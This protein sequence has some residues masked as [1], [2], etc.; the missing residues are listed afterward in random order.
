MMFFLFVS[1]NSFAAEVQDDIGILNKTDIQK[2]QQTKYPFDLTI[3]VTNFTIEGFENYFKNKE[4]VGIGVNPISK[5]TVVTSPTN[6]EI[7]GLSKL[8]N[9]DFTSARYVD[10]ISKIANEYE[11][12]LR[13][14]IM[15]N[16]MSTYITYSLA[17][18]FVLLFV[19]FLGLV[20]NLA[21]K[22][23][24]KEFEQEQE[25]KLDKIIKEEFTR[26]ENTNHVDG[27]KRLAHKSSVNIDKK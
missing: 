22:K 21:R 13:K 19:G 11:K 27:A 15:H 5:I 17:I 4:T 26:S 18:C 16:E 1:A 10:G 8:G 25:K 24:K 14:E 20:L 9:K 6:L 23:R 3:L 7:R 2:L 12:R